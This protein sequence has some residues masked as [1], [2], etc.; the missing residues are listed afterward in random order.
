MRKIVNPW[1][2]NPEFQCFGC[3]EHNPMGLQMKMEEGENGE[4][5]SHWSPKAYFQGWHD[6]LHGGIQCTLLDE[7]AAWVVFHD[8]NAS[9]V[10]VKLETKFLK[11]VYSSDSELLIKGKLVKSAHSMAW[12]ETS[13]TNSKGEVCATADAVY[14]VFSREISK[15]EFGFDELTYEEEK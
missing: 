5:I 15:N 3:S 11:T 14:K 7:I 4:I 2:R 13:I 8:L 6:V 1:K 10:T 12:I 9:G